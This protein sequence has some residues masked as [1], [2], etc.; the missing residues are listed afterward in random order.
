MHKKLSSH[1]PDATSAVSQQKRVLTA[2]RFATSDAP[3]I[4]ERGPIFPT[5]VI[6]LRL[7]EVKAIT[8]LSKTSL[9]EMIR[10]D[11]FPKPISLGP[12]AVAWVRSEVQRWAIDRIN[13]A[14]MAP[15]QSPNRVRSTSTN[16]TTN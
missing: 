12:R 5:D 4:A 3:R 14:R 8:G 16:K 7:P 1:R 10:I 2:T 9:Y 6:F 13:A 11:Q 15:L